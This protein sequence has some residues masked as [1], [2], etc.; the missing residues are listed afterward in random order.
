MKG[1][2]NINKG[3][4]RVKG[5]WRE[6]GGKVV[7]SL[8]SSILKSGKSENIKINFAVCYKHINENG[9]KR[10]FF[11]VTHLKLLEILIIFL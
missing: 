9:Q 2:M 3:N 7:Y 8:Y 11:N 5:S 10:E 6:I 4:K 1:E